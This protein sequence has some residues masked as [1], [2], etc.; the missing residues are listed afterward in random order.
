VLTQKID[1]LEQVLGASSLDRQA[2]NALLRQLFQSITLDY[3]SGSFLFT[4]QHGAES[5]LVVTFP[6]AF[7]EA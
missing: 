2:A 4:W 1:E 7:N 5:D 6:E 3:S